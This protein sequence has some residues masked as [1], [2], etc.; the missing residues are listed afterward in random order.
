MD[1]RTE[2]LNQCSLRFSHAF[3]RILKALRQLDDGQ[4]WHRPSPSSNSIGILLQHLE[5]NLN[6]W[7]YAGV[8]GKAFRRERE[9]EFTRENGA[10]RDQALALLHGLEAR[11]REVIANVPEESL[12]DPRRIQGFDE[13]IMSALMAALTHLELHAGQII[14]MTKLMLRDKYVVAWKPANPEQGKA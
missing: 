7:I 2:F 11:V 8:G 6:Q 1:V 9:A 3:A 10:T 5:G 4:L 14:Y 12:L 13:S